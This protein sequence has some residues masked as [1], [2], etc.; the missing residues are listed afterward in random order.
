[1]PTC[2]VACF[3]LVPSIAMDATINASP[4]AP[5]T[6]LT[7]TVTSLPPHVTCRA[8]VFANAADREAQF[9]TVGVEEIFP[10]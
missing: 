8:K 10:S 2:V 3:S 6:V 5:P 9:S 7:R 4:R 1:M